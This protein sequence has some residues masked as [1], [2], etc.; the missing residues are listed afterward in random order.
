MCTTQ[1]I[2]QSQYQP[3]RRIT[4]KRTD[5]KKSNLITNTNK[6]NNMITN[7]SRLLMNDKKIIGT[8]YDK[9]KIKQIS[10][11]TS[12]SPLSLE[13]LRLF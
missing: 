11:H 7:T 5:K 1:N 2:N 3:Q 12:P 13:P 9:R 10:S 8:S 4:N 6:D